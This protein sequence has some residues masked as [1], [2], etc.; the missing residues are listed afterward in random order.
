MRSRSSLKLTELFT[1]LAAA[2]TF[3]LI[4][5]QTEAQEL[6]PYPILY[7][8]SVVIN[9]EFAPLGTQ[10]S[11]RVG[12]YV[13]DVLVEEDG[14]YR[15]LLLQPPSSEYYGLEITF[16]ILGALAEQRDT[17]IQSGGPVFKYAGLSAF[18]LKF[19]I[20]TK[21]L[22][23]PIPSHAPASIATSSNSALIAPLQSSSPV[24]TPSLTPTSA[25]T[26]DIS[27]PADSIEDSN[28][29]FWQLLLTFAVL[30]ILIV[31]VVC[32][33]RWKKGTLR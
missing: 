23:S 25:L 19:T 29:E 5:G 30:A 10:L 4:A 6:P 17:F 14:A 8:G 2:V 27:Y 11:A 20:V 21:G 1:A 7:G 3:L 28:G 13:T 31:A 18:N 15:N 26:P 24:P 16:H 9:G 32:A 12:D 33:L 22:P